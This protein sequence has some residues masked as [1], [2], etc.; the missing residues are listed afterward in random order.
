MLLSPFLNTLTHII[1]YVSGKFGKLGKLPTNCFS[2]FDH[3]VGLG[4]KG[5]M[6]IIAE[7]L[8]LVFVAYGLR[9]IEK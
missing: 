2:V 5:L 1:V 7:S 4:L 9:E 8:C 6:I 3:F